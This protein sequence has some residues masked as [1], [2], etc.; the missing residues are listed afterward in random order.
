M[1]KAFCAKKLGVN[2][3]FKFPESDL[4]MRIQLIHVKPPPSLEY[5]LYRFYIN[6][7]TFV[8]LI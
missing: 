8:F 7:Y 2:A 1:Q 6:N 5:N 4:L 3:C